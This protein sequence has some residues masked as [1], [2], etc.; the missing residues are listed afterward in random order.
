MVWPIHLWHLPD[1]LMK[2][3]PT[4]ESVF[5][6]LFCGHFQCFLMP[7]SDTVQVLGMDMAIIEDFRRVVLSLQQRIAVRISSLNKRKLPTD[8]RKWELS[9][10]EMAAYHRVLA[11]EYAEVDVVDDRVWA[12][13]EMTRIYQ[14]LDQTVSP[15]G[16]Q[17]LY[18]LLK[19]YQPNAE[20]LAENAKAYQ[21]FKMQPKAAARL[22]VAL[23]QMNR[24]E[25]AELADFLFGL[26]PAI[27]PRYRVFYLLSALSVAC[28][29]GLIISAR[30]LL[31]AIGFCSLNIV[32]YYL[33]G[34]SVFRYADALKSVAIM[35]GC[36]PNICGALLDVDLPE[37]AELT[38]T[39][40]VAKVIQ[41]Q[42]SRAFLRNYSADPIIEL[43][44]D[45]LNLLF[46]F[47]LTALCRAI[48]TVNEKRT[49]LAS[50]FRIVARLDAFQGLTMALSDYP[51][52]CVPEL[53]SGRR[54]TLTNVYHPLVNHPVS[55]SLE[56]AGMSILLSGTNMAGKTTFIKTLGLNV[57]LAQTLGLCLARKAI[58]PPA[59]VRTL[60]ERQDTITTGQSYFFFEAA[61]LLRMSKEADRSD[62]EFWFVLDEVFR[63]T[64][65]IE[66]VAA[67]GAVLNH[68][69]RRGFVVA[70]THDHELTNLLRHEFE[71]YHF[72]EVIDGDEARFDYRLRKGACLT[73]NAIKLL[74]LAGYPKSVTEMAE[75]L[76]ASSNV[77][78]IHPEEKL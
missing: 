43:I 7:C 62:R 17:Y 40:E 19:H 77:A 20:S 16:A 76:T 3:L 10:A 49:E 11:R 56:G 38:T 22:R 44:V 30:F 65:A 6:V 64:N 25:S 27:P 42:I 73:R 23:A 9:S 41:K 4:P 61:E 36:L 18:A 70:S 46:L 63:G 28:L 37:A 53:Q 75:S 47:E 48:H 13:L 34:R 8:D 71:S 24:K 31:P 60:I 1:Q 55:N 66:R 35:L 14:K 57:V 72:S 74:T 32:L 51:S 15:L 2:Q 52:V 67:G 26:P 69:N 50:L 29:F 54:F 58:L 68:L 59:R 78:W 5:F 12:D 45:Y 21:T 39:A 33:Y